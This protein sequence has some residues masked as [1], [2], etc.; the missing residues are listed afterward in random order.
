MSEQRILVINP[1]SSEAVTTGIDRS[2]ERLRRPS[3]PAIEC[4][5]LDE[6]PPGIETAA[7]I[8][9]V[10]APLLNLLEKTTASAYVIA[11][12]S[13][14]G[15]SAARRARPEPVYGIAE[16]AFKEAKTL[17]ERFGIIAIKDESTIRHRRYVKELG[18]EE[19][20]AES[21]PV[22][23]AVTELLDET[24][25]LSRL[26]DIGLRL[27]DDNGAEVLVLGCTGMAP[28]R[29]TL[30]EALARPVVEPCQAAA[31]EALSGLTN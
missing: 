27:R 21:L 9:G 18:F 29:N 10:V 28:Y 13:D 20:F 15:L 5:T 24:R 11:C 1:N 8:E 22:G 14:P 25:A 17:G 19:R 4:M 26:I 12:F 7:D 23:L 30:E 6:G 31:R 16:S 2:L 3:G